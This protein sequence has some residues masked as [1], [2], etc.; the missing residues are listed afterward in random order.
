MD[1]TDVSDDISIMDLLVEPSHG[2]QSSVVSVAVQ[3][4]ILRQAQT[5][6]TQQAGED[7]V[8]D[9]VPNNQRTIP[10][11]QI[12]TQ[13]SSSFREDGMSQLSG[14]S[15]NDASDEISIMD[16][17]GDPTSGDGQ[18]SSLVSAEVQARILL[19]AQ[20]LQQDQDRGVDGEAS[21][22]DSGNDDGSMPTTDSSGLGELSDLSIQDLLVEASSHTEQGRE[23]SAAVQAMILSEAQSLERLDQNDTKTKSINK[24]NGLEVLKL[25]KQTAANKAGFSA[26]PQT[27]QKLD[28]TVNAGAKGETKK[29]EKTWPETMR[30]APITALMSSPAEEV[31]WSAREGK[32]IYKSPDTEKG[33]SSALDT[34][35]SL[36]SLPGA[37]RV[38]GISSENFDQTH[39]DFDNLLSDSAD[40]EANRVSSREAPEDTESDVGFRGK[41]ASQL[42]SLTKS[43]FA[44]KVERSEGGASEVYDGEVL[45]VELSEKEEKGMSRRRRGAFIMCAVCATIVVAVL[46]LVIALSLL[47]TRDATLDTRSRLPMPST[48]PSSSPQPSL[49]SQPSSSPSVS[50]SRSSWTLVSN[51][52]REGELLQISASYVVVGNGGTDVGVFQRDTGQQVGADLVVNGYRQAR[53]SRDGSKVAICTNTTVE[54]FH[55]VN[56]SNRWDLQMN[57]SVT[58]QMN[59]LHPVTIS[60]SMSSDASVLAILIDSTFT[61]EIA[62]V[63]PQKNGAWVHKGRNVVKVKR[64]WAWLSG[65][66]D[67]LYVSEI[68][69]DR[70]AIVV[71]GQVLTY[72]PVDDDWVVSTGQRQ[73]RALWDSEG[74]INVALSDDA[75]VIATASAA[76]LII[77]GFVTGFEGLIPI[78]GWD[79]ISVGWRVDVS[80]T[81]DGSTVAF[82]GG[83]VWNSSAVSVNVFTFREN[84]EIKGVTI[85]HEMGTDQ[86][87]LS[88]QVCISD[89]GNTVGVGVTAMRDGPRVQTSYYTFL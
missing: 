11:E 1:K 62:V 44:Y 82:T 83:A 50:P 60:I 21:L 10:S 12:R 41:F 81:P 66:G 89:D 35:E 23:V 30:L 73:Y 28:T 88:V 17:I 40:D 61:T 20:M 43:I 31:L 9:G 86:Q 8:D 29:S 63:E 13:H 42:W 5:A 78:P 38:R 80:L 33:V 72:T 3:A 70:L 84:W 64:L 39:E 32:K 25:C 74:L 79:D 57:Y 59:E 65:D 85:F 37:F 77:W 55:Y 49:S 34:S 45:D 2:P 58:N 18:R 16:L 68:L 75:K 22:I 6:A 27:V 46:S 48:A 47:V 26:L 19:E 52:A 4:R 87:P 15:L 36:S 69:D 7:E 71:F 24:G 56:E 51:I 53:L 67:H 54:L 76:G 14:S